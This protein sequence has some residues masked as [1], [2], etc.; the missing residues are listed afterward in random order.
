VIVDLI[1]PEAKDPTC[2]TADFAEPF[3]ALDFNDVVA[4]LNAFSAGDA[5]ADLADPIGAFD[6]NDVVAYLSAF[7]AGCP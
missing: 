7:S 6:F 3:G 1:L 4:F 5:S 2:G